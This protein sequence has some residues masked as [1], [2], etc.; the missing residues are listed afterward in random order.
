VAQSSTS[1][2]QRTTKREAEVKKIALLATF[3]ALGVSLSIYPGSIPIGPTK[4]FP[5]QHMINGILGVTLG[6]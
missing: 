5:F 6:P 3:I 2:Q 4:V 1:T